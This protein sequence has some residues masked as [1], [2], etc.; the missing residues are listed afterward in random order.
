MS[1]L[2]AMCLLTGADNGANHFVFNAEIHSYNNYL[3]AFRSGVGGNNALTSAPSVKKALLIRL[4][5]MKMYITNYEG[6]NYYKEDRGLFAFNTMYMGMNGGVDDI[7]GPPIAGRRSRGVCS[8]C[9]SFL[10]E[11]VSELHS[12]DI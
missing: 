7:F 10:Y 12:G 6:F 11:S 9:I 3:K 8:V 4:S 2:V 1:R 5:A